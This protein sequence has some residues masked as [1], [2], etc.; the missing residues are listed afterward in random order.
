MRIS[1]WSSDVCS[2]DL[3]SRWRSLSDLRELRIF[4][5]DSLLQNEDVWKC[6]ARL[7]S[8]PAQVKAWP[9][10][11][12]CCVVTGWN[13]IPRPAVCMEEAHGQQAGERDER[14]EQCV[15]AGRFWRSEEPTSELQ[16]LMRI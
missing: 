14:R 5:I 4:M 3:L 11:F 2:S 9:R 7:S 16:S 12:A 1:D 13:L 10:H 6:G 15:R 8:R